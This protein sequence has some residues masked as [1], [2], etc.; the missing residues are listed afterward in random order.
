MN[1]V[2][3]RT[4]VGFFY[5]L[6]LLLTSLLSSCESSNPGAA[7]TVATLTA[8]GVGTTGATLNGSVNANG[9]ATDAWFEWGT[10]PDLAT[11]EKSPLQALGAGTA[12]LPVT[13]TLTGL[14]GGT[15]YYHRVAASNSTGTAKG[16]IAPFTTASPTAFGVVSTIPANGATDVPLG[17]LIAVTFNED[18]E[19]ATLVDAIAVSSLAGNVPG[20]I[21]YNSTTRTATFTPSTPLAPLTDYTVT[22]DGKVKATS[23]ERLSTPYVFGF[24][25]GVVG[26]LGSTPIATSMEPTSIDGTTATLNGTV[27]PN[28]LATRAWFEYGTDPGLQAYA[29]TPGQDAGN[30]LIPQ[31]LSASVSALTPGTAYYF[32]VHAENSG[33]YSDGQILN[34]TTGSPGSPPAVT[35]M[36]ATSV[37]TTGATLN[38]SV[39]PN[40]LATNA[41][42]EWGTDPTLAGFGSTVAQALGSGTTSQAIQQALPGLSTGTVYYYRVAASNG[43]GTSKGAVLSVVPGAAPSVNTLTATGVGTTVATL[44]GSVNPNGLATDAWFEWGTSPGLATFSKS[45][46][47]ALGAGTSPG[48]VTTTLSGL[49]SGTTYY[50]RV[51]AANS[52]GPA[53]GSIASCTTATPGSFGVVST[54]PANQATD[55]PRGSAI[56]VTFSEDVEPATLVGAIT[57]GSVAGY[58]PGVT[59]YNSTTKTAIFTPGTP[60]APLTDYTV[61]VAAKVKSVTTVRLSAPYVFGF[62]SGT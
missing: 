30:G 49:S 37:G 1:P 11:F 28:G 5:L 44:N 13:A 15:T 45:P 3:T 4:G 55:V 60:L 35:T 12:P 14:S 10:S 54:T 36:E 22:V 16:T 62:R 52:T 43:S 41:W 61:T 38:G 47:Q 21:S 17:S 32:R 50:Y 34:F 57:V 26:N 20:V 27:N 46:L 51:A 18:V 29:S 53:N 31:S 58:L 19:P 39:I 25:S 2:R 23:T 42:F 33:G 59:S 24:R 56:T 6:A 8:T 40:G 7:P 48:S 9:L